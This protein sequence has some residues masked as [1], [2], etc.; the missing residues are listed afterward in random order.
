MKY[1]VLLKAPSIAC[2]R[3]DPFNAN[4][5]SRR[6]WIL[7]WRR[8]AI[9]RPSAL[10][11]RGSPSRSACQTQGLRQ[12]AWGEN[13][14]SEGPSVPETVTCPSRRIFSANYSMS[15]RF[16][17]PINRPSRH[18]CQTPD[19]DQSNA[20]G[21]IY[22]HR[23]ITFTP[24]QYLNIIVGDHELRGINISGKNSGCAMGNI[25]NLGIVI[26]H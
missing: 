26:N 20:V 23:N 4:T 13:F 10:D 3:Y 15:H 5:S 14:S 16:C 12:S 25:M 6:T 24:S 2:L 1:F 8:P 7:A 17:P 11:N 19:W 9:V 18:W 22:P 21:L